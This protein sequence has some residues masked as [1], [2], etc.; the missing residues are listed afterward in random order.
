MRRDI[1]IPSGDYTV[2]PFFVELLFT[3]GRYSIKRIL[4]NFAGNV[5]VVD[6]GIYVATS[7][8]LAAGLTPAVRAQTEVFADAAVAA[9]ADPAPEIN[10][11]GQPNS[12]DIRASESMYVR[13][14]TVDNPVSGN[15][16][17]FL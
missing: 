9:A 13:I 10:V 4:A 17:I 8:L 7:G 11:I 3:Q 5:G 15:L 16:S 12:C 14:F 1:P 2:N 6:V